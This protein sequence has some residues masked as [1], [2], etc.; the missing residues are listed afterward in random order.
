MKKLLVSSN[1]LFLV[2]CLVVLGLFV[3]QT[4]DK[5]RVIEELY[6][7]NDKTP[8]TQFAN[9]LLSFGHTKALSKSLTFTLH[10]ATSYRPQQ[11]D[12]F[13]ISLDVE[14]E[15]ATE[16]SITGALS[17]LPKDARLVV[18]DET[19]FM[20]KPRRLTQVGL[21][22]DTIYSEIK[23]PDLL[24][25]YSEEL[26]RRSESHNQGKK[27]EF[28]KKLRGWVTFFFSDNAVYERPF[29]N[30]ISRVKEGDFPA[31]IEF[32]Y[33]NYIVDSNEWYS[34]QKNLKGQ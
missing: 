33:G 18:Y 14:I 32:Y 1:K 16:E 20:D 11:K 24:T 28:P 30:K 4:I 26:S 9:L 8:E 17:K 15:G 31:F 34:Y 21:L 5:Q 13:L 29:G 2:A 25:L 22:L 7:C 23:Q 19:L 6:K 12:W 10:S 27:Y 3:Y